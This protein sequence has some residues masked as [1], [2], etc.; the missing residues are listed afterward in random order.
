MIRFLE[1]LKGPWVLVGKSLEAPS[2]HGSPVR[3][4]RYGDEQFVEARSEKTP[5]GW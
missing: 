1:T 3:A 2:P 5:R 4:G